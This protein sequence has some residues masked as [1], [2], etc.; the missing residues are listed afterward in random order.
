MKIEPNYEEI[1]KGKTDY[2]GETLAAFH[3]AA[4][5]F[6]KQ[7]HIWALEV[8]KQRGLKPTKECNCPDPF[9]CIKICN[10]LM[11]RI[12]INERGAK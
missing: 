5:E 1:L 7:Y 9:A 2:Y 11:D 10:N 8:A 12:I 6:A 4:I 3:F